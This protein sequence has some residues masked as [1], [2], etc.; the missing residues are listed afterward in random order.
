MTV[1]NHKNISGITSITTPA[2]SD[3]LFT[4]HTNDTT[5]RFRIDASGHQNISGIITAANFK[6][7]TSNL[8]STG[9]NIQDLDV[10]GHTNLDNISIAGVSTFSGAVN[11]QALTATT[12]T[13][14]GNVSIGGTLTYE[15]VT[16]IDAVGVITARD[17]VQINADNKYLKIGAGNDI[18]IVHTGGES[19]IANATGH[20]T[21]RSDVHK[22]ENYNAS[23]EYLRILSGGEVLIGRTAKPNDINK[24]VVTGTSPADTYD[25]TLYL[26]GS[27]TS[28]AV[29][30]GG[31]LAFG[32]HDGG[33]ARNWGNIYGMKENGSSGHTNSYMSFHTRAQGGN[34]TERLRIDSSGKVGIGTDNIRT[35][36]AA[37]LEI[38]GVG[39]TPTPHLTL[40]RMNTVGNG[41]DLGIICFAGDGPGAVNGN[42][43]GAQIYAAGT[44]TWTGSSY[45]ADLIFRTTPSGATSPTE[46]LRISSDGKINTG[47]PA[48]LA[49]DDFNITATGTGAT[50]SL[51]RAKTGNASDNDLLGALSFQSY[52]AG[53]GY[54]SAEAGIRAYAATGQSGSAAPTELRFYTKPSTVGP[55]AGASERLRITPDGRFSLGQ[56][57]TASPGAVFHIDWDSNN[58]LMLDNNS[59]STQKMFF[60]SQGAVHAQIYGTSASGAVTIESDPSNNHGSSF[61]NFKVDNGEAFR[62]DTSGRLKI[63]H[64]D[65]PGQLDDTFLSIYDTNTDSGISKN[66]AMIALHNYGTGST[67]DVAGI[68]FGAGSS[69]TYT[70]GSIAFQRTDSYG[71]GALSFYTNND[72]DTTLVNDTD[73]RMRIASNG[74]VH[75]GNWSSQGTTYGKARL[76]IRGVDNIATSFALASSYLHIGGQEST[77]G[78]LY[79]I[80]FGHTKASY[81]KASSYIGAKVTDSASAEKTSLVFATRDA[82]T[83]SDPTERLRI[84]HD[85]IPTIPL[86]PTAHQSINA[87]A[88][89]NTS[90]RQ[91]ASNNQFQTNGTNNLSAGWYTIAACSSGRASGRI[92]IRD[93]ASSRHQAVTFYAAHH[94]GGGTSQNC[95]NTIFSSGRHS[96]N[97]LGALRIKAYGTY[98]GAMVQVY[99]RDGTNNCQAF[100]LGDNLQTQGWIMKNWVAD[101]TDPGTVSNH[102]NIHNNMSTP[103]SY[104]D[105][106]ELQGGG[107]SSGGHIIPDA[108]N[109][110]TLGRGSYRWHEIFCMN[111]SNTTSDET[112]KQDIAALTTAEMNAAKR[113]SALFKTYRWKDAVTEKGT[114]KARTHTGIIAQQVKSAM[115]AESLDPAKYSFYCSDEWYEDSNGTKLPLDTATRQGDSVGV[116]TNTTLGGSIVVPTGFNKVTR[117][118]IRYVELLAF[119][120]AYNEQ[121]F[122][123]IES[124]LTALE[125]S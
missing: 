74:D 101:G 65:H 7:G 17:G 43:Y 46:K 109:R 92:G 73:E 80:S 106:N 96:G 63:N 93:L 98:D 16:N 59:A 115:E 35:T 88:L 20:L 38:G 25:S 37:T 66:Y 100:L 90:G 31:A 112:L 120:S 6:T 19:V 41:N 29:N 69:F 119:I 1:I 9:L 40:R 39:G 94:Y 23:T 83:D 57:I 105:L 32:G 54:A 11:T 47:D 2:G 5:E 42:R 49:T 125:S 91:P 14:S 70:K 27:E 51:N 77:L 104:S 103:G 55:G 30:T 122:T 107:M 34:P 67:G 13:F 84:H 87:S 102:A 33:A 110:W 82:V 60:A 118:S 44:G 45:P 18:S 15:D 99:L 72:G 53:Q 26:E 117:Y 89:V 4:V 56:S 95:I 85:G 10:D 78:G 64:T 81:T 52:P 68:G 76:N 121:R 123:S 124:R 50:L 8:H 114:D 3:N 71:R 79:P 75:L 24:L 108:D 48:S 113:L 36:S 86:S 22:W 58:L 28:G 12:G 111:S 21:R 116:G 97:P 62:I 61:I